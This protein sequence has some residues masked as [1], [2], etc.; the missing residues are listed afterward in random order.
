MRP[1]GLECSTSGRSE[2]ILLKMAIH[3][4]MFSSYD[5]DNFSIPVGIEN[6]FQQ[7]TSFFLDFQEKETAKTLTLFRKRVSSSPM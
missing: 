4:D 2:D 7:I 1:T 3:G 6:G 5:N